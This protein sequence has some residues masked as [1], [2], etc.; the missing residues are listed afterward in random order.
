MF[1][2][3][4]HRDRTP[5]GATFDTIRRASTRP[6]RSHRHAT[7][8]GRRN[9][10]GRAPQTRSS[11]TPLRLVHERPSWRRS[12]CTQLQGICRHA[13]CAPTA[14][15]KTFPCAEV[16]RQQRLDRPMAGHSQSRLGNGRARVARR[17][18]ACRAKGIGGEG[19]RPRPRPLTMF[20][21]R[22]E[23][24]HEF[25]E[26]RRTQAAA[27]TRSLR[28]V[29]V[30]RPRFTPSNAA[31]TTRSSAKNGLGVSNDR[32]HA[33]SRKGTLVRRRLSDH[34]LHQRR[35]FSGGNEAAV[36]LQQHH[37]LCRRSLTLAHL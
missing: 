31:A 24:R 25:F 20:A 21:L 32:I 7:T 23:S 9:P 19:L 4:Q 33:L 5:Q 22:L 27:S 3:R 36:H 6:D 14:R 12:H 2:R 30:G 34:R 18:S 11:Q 26:V 16:R 10:D 28:R 8:R 15:A 37:E 35:A 13:R 29:S 17:V 1:H